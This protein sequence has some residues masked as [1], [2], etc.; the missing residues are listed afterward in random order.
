MSFAGYVNV[1]VQLYCVSCHC[2]TLHVFA[3]MAIFRCVVYFY[4][5]MSEGI[6]IA[7]FFAFFLTW[8]HSARFHLRFS[9]LFSFVSFVV[10]CVHVCLFAACCTLVTAG[11]IY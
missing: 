6:C 4:F 8:S 1:C 2:L 9:V 7:G 3:Y 11:V 10:S 5:H